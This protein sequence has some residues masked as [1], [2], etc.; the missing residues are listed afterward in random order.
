MPRSDAASTV[1]GG[2]PRSFILLFGNCAQSL[3]SQK[4]FCESTHLE[5]QVGQALATGVRPVLV[6]LPA[7]GGP[8]VRKLDGLDIWLLRDDGGGSV[9][10]GL[11]AA[12]EAF[13]QVP[14]LPDCGL[15]VLASQPPTAFDYADALLRSAWEAPLGLASRDGRWPIAARREVLAEMAHDGFERCLRGRAI[16]NAAS[17]LEAARMAQLSALE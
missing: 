9:D 13:D 5:A 16:R 14:R 15:L 2:R 10:A 8:V 11:R 17:F 6:V 1:A 12:G 4:S 3:A 7:R